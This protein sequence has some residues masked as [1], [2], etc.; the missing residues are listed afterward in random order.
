MIPVASSIVPHYSS[1]VLGDGI[2][3][4]SLVE[5]NESERGELRKLLKSAIDVV[6]IGLR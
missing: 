4:H 1:N 6:D 5:V 3:A 2:G